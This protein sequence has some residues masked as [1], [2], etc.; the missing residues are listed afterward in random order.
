M[1]LTLLPLEAYSIPT[2]PIWYALKL[3]PLWQTNKST[4]KQKDK[5]NKRKLTNARKN[6]EPITNVQIRP[7]KLLQVVP[8]IFHRKTFERLGN[9]LEKVRDTVF[10]TYAECSGEFSRLNISISRG[11]LISL[12]FKVF[13]YQLIMMHFKCFGFFPR[14]SWYWK[15]NSGQSNLS[16][17]C[18]NVRMDKRCIAMVQQLVSFCRLRVI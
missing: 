1:I 9:D 3:M 11:R 8:L 4:K 16:S 17:L 12:H 18:F 13:K 10:Q 6:S 2:F 5:Q 15:S 14:Q 7:M